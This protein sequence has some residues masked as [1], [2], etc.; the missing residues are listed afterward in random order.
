MIIGLGV[1]MVELSRIRKVMQEQPH[2]LH[3]ILTTV[4]LQELPTKEQRRVEYVAGRFAVKEAAAKALGTGIGQHLSWLDLEVT[5]QP[6][7]EPQL[8][9]SPQLSHHHPRLIGLHATEL[10]SWCSLSHTQEHAIAQ[11]ILECKSS[12]LT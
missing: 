6:S 8:S 1:D 9:L 10:I 3:R 2:F 4:E 5:N 7:G 11:V 12:L